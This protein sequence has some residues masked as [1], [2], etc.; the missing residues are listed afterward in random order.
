M[1]SVS[2]VK[3][4]NDYYDALLQA[5]DDIGEKPV[6]RGDRVLIKPNLYEPHAPDSGEITNPRLV[7]AVAR[8]CLDAGAGRVI[9]GEGPSYYQP[10]SRLKKCF[11][12]PGISEVADRLGIEWVLLTNTNSALSGVSPEPRPMNS[13]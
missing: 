7:E 3:V 8:Y 10:E 4:E 6:S 9:I 13:G 2:I 5:L 12:E 1:S 11:T